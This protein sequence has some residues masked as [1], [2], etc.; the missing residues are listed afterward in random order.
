MKQMLTREGKNTV[1]ISTYEQLATLTIWI[2]SWINWQKYEDQ[3]QKMWIFLQ[4]T[5]ALL[6]FT[7]RT[8]T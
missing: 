5:E 6:H 2:I 4:L 8:K 7:L 3:T 1:K